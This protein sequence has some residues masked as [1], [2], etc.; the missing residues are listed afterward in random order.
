MRDARD[1]LWR[2]VE[3]TPHLD[4]LLLTKRPENIERFIPARWI[5]NYP[6]NAWLGV[7]AE[8]QA[9]ADERIPLLLQAPAKVRFVSVEPQ[10]EEINLGLL[11]TIPGSSPYALVGDGIDLVICG[12]E[13]GPKARRFDENWARSLRDQCVEAGVSYFYK[14]KLDAKGHK[15]GMPELDGKVWDELPCR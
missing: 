3:Q 6:E 13:S 4:W 2:M 9:M 11:G 12:S 14:Q 1:R 10:L 8:N 7:T 15:I 5:D